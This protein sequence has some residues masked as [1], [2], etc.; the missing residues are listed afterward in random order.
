VAAPWRPFW[1][2]AGGDA[3]GFAEVQDRAS[4]SAIDRHLLTSV[5]ILQRWAAAQS[6]VAAMVM[7]AAHGSHRPM[8]T[9]VEE[10]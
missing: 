4:A 1:G 8:F 10:C 2:G 5:D 3:P 7:R 6:R 9:N